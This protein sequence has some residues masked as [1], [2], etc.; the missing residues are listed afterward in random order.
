MSAF[1]VRWFR[2]PLEWMYENSPLFFAMNDRREGK[3]GVWLIRNETRLRND[4]PSS[5]ETLAAEIEAA[6]GHPVHASLAQ[7]WLRIAQA[8]WNRDD[9]SAGRKSA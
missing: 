2:R 7:H 5:M 9:A 3:I 6:I 4:P 8:E 1:L